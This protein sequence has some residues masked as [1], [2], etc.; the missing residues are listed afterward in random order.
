M[1]MG[2]AVDFH[3]HILPG[4]DDGSSSEEQSLAMLAMETEQGIT[5][6]VATPH[7]YPHRDT[8]ERFLERRDGA[9]LRL[10]EAMIGHDELPDLIVGAEVGYFR[11]MSQSEYLP[12]LAVRGTRCIL[13]EMPPAPWTEE[14]YR[15]LEEIKRMQGLTSVIAHVDRYIT[16]L[17]RH[18]IPGRLVRLPVLVQAN[19]DFF[20]RP[21]TAGMALKMLKAGQIHLLGSDCHNTSTRKPNLGGALEQI[22]RKLGAEAVSR[23]AACEQQVLNC[24][25][26]SGRDVRP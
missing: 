25:S 4:I 19:A 11:G 12:R 18:G 16:P 20:L 23:I 15:E 22:E 3:S 21:A 6:V 17:R 2:N 9:E 14:M 10:R 26:L 5:R 24:I 8:P 1:T 7:F 13:I